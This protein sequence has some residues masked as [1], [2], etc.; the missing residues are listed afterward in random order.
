MKRT[1]LFIFSVLLCLVTQL[2][3]STYYVT[4]DGNDENA[5]T[6]THPWGTW[7]KAF[8]SAQPGDTVYFREGTW[9]LGAGEKVTYDPQAGHGNK[10]TYS[11]WICFMNYP[12]ETPI[13]DASG[14][15]NFE[16]SFEVWHTS[17]VLIKGLVFQGKKQK[18]VNQIIRQAVFYENGTIKLENCVSR[19][20][21]GY[22]FT[23]NAWDTLYVVNCDSY[24]HFDSFM[25][26]PYEPGNKADGFAISS[27][28]ETTD[29]GELMGC[30]AWRCSDDGFEA[31][32]S[33]DML[34]D[35]CWTFCNGYGSDLA[36]GIGIKYGQ[37]Y[38]NHADNRITQRCVAAWNKGPGYVFQNLNSADNG[39]IGNFY[40]NLSYHNLYGFGS[41]ISSY[42]T[43]CDEG[44]T[45]LNFINN[46]SYNENL[47]RPI[48]LATCGTDM[49]GTKWFSSHNTFYL[50]PDNMSYKYT[51]ND[52]VSWANTGK[53]NQWIS[54]PD[55]ATTLVLLSAPRKTDGS[56]PS[57]GNAFKLSATSNLIDAGVDVG[58]PYWGSA[59]DM[60]PFEYNPDTTNAINL[61][62]LYNNTLLL[63]P[64]PVS[65]DLHIKLSEEWDNACTVQIYNVCGIKVFENK[66]LNEKTPTINVTN[67]PKGNYFIMVSD[68]FKLKTTK[69]VVQ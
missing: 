32:W 58:L 67:F 15:T 4:V 49:I 53:D 33:P 9:Y 24:E 17:Y 55:S 22:G 34:I 30:R 69:F 26:P 36:A 39:P 8:D 19:N 7:Q 41:V 20:S 65:D 25:E 62:K 50:N 28:G 46:I 12:G 47:S 21:G 64:N 5:G 1:L 56:L 37:G 63:Y 2:S 59:P 48:N 27:G 6:I 38:I 57:I 29:Y 43:D 66:Y 54:L 51:W 40:N 18:T 13:L 44:S 10:G 60:G 23:I 52:T 3:A 11:N 45:Y 42:F 14:T 35:N 16:E 31:S 68:D 61:V